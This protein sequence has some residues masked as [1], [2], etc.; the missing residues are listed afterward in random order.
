MTSLHVICGLG[1]PQ[2]K[3]LATPMVGGAHF[4]LFAP[5]G[6]TT[7]WEEMEQRRQAITKIVSDLSGPRFEPSTPETNAIPLDLLDGAEIWNRL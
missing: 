3:I 2:S 1:P 4:R 7:F 5:S 6:N